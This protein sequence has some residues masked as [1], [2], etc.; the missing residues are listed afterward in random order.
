MILE[1]ITLKVEQ[2]DVI[3][4]LGKNGIGKSTLLRVLGKISQPDK[5]SLIH[6]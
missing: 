5:L 3:A 1:D 2:G 6:I 4:L